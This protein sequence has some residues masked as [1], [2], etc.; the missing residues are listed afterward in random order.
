M[1]GRVVIHWVKDARAK[2]RKPEAVMLDNMHIAEVLPEIYAGEDFPGYANINHCYAVLEKLWLDFKQDWVTALTHCQGVYLI[3]DRSTGLRYVGSAYGEDG[4][5]S[6][7]ANYFSSGGHG[8]NKLLKKLLLS[9]SNGIDYAR[10][11]FQFSLLEQASSR[12]S[13]QY[14]I[15]RESY[16]KETLLTRGEYG[17]NDN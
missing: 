14:I 10:K 4:I 1:I 16:W 12:D 2:G 17:L 15:Q 7:W 6:R 13:E 11:N 9:K 5:F 8:G 3:T